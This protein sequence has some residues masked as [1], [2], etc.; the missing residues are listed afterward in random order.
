VPDEWIRQWG[1]PVLR[2]IAAPVL[3]ADDILRAQV[4]RMKRRLDD[5]DGAGLAG[6]QVGFLRRAFVFRAS[7]EDRIEA[8]V[9]PAIVAASTE[10][11]TFVEGCLSFQAVVVEVERPVAVRVEA[12]TLEGRSLVLD[13]EGYRASLLQ[14]EIDHLNGVLT[15]DRADPAERRRAMG[16]LLDRAR[17]DPQATRLAA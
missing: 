4:D 7:L 1:D 17:I 6:T 15:L 10:R 12:Q 3:G 11:A 5:A 13:V 14:H 8:L 9:N 2:E 16:V